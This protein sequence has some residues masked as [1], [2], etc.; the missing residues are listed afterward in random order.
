[1]TPTP[2]AGITFAV[3]VDDAGLEILQQRTER[4]QPPGVALAGRDG[5]AQRG[6]QVGVDLVDDQAGVALG[7][8]H[9]QRRLRHA[10]GGQDR[11]RLQPE[12]LARVQQVLDVG[13]VD[14]LGAGQR[15]PQRR[16]VVLTRLGLLAQPLGEQRVGEVG[17]RGHGALVLVDQLG[18]QQRVAQEVHRRDLDQL[19]AE[20]HRDGQEAD[21]AHVV[22]AGQ[23]ADHDVLVDVVLGAD[24]H[25]LGVGVDV[26]VRDLDGLRRS[27]RPGRQ[28]HQRQV[29]FVRSRP[30]RSARPR[31]GRRS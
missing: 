28:L 21:H 12:G 10:V 25:G 9:R 15:E 19:G 22:E 14:G 5:A 6:Q 16:Q 29:V 18:P 31:A 11:R 26:A 1:M 17:R 2:R 4:C 3:L 13:G 20:V 8:R 24:E 23:P 7:E 30:D 27:G